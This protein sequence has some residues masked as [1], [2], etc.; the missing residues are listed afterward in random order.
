MSNE[1][2]VLVVSREPVYI[3]PM[4]DLVCGMKVDP[5][6]AAASVEFEGETYYFCS[7]GCAKKFSQNPASFLKPQ[8]ST[9]INKTHEADTQIYTC[10]MHPQI[11]QLGPGS[12]PICGMALEPKH[13]TTVAEQ[14]NPE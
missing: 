4:I 9:E 11:E 5:S 1:F 2:L 8:A 7:K 12:C 3:T 10:P 13:I 6:S 14:E